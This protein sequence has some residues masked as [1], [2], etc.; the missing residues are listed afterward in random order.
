MRK[1]P[2]RTGLALVPPPASHLIRAR[3]DPNRY[4]HAAQ[5]TQP[6]HAPT[7]PTRRIRACARNL[8]RCAD[9]SGGSWQP[10]CSLCA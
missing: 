3:A 10:H 7:Q 2:H 1:G 9:C 8:L 6:L 5:D 4:Q